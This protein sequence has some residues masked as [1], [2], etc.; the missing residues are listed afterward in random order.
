MRLPK[1]WK[2]RPFDEDGVGLR[3]IE[4]IRPPWGRSLRVI[5]REPDLFERFSLS[6]PPGKRIEFGDA[7][8]NI[9][10]TRAER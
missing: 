10:V 2:S 7:Q 4:P 9:A 1:G 3:A 6:P 5:E 8:G